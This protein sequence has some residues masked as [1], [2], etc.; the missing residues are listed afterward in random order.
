MNDVI[1]F[2]RR[3]QEER[4]AALRTSDRKVRIAHLRFAEAYETKVRDLTAAQRRA[5]LQIV[6]VAERQHRA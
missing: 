3:A 5:T 2:S 6:G 1:Y 4:E